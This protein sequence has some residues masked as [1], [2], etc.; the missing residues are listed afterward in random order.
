MEPT[1]A[2]S[3]QAAA[4]STSALSIGKGQPNKRGNGGKAARQALSGANGQSPSNSMN[5]TSKRKGEPNGRQTASASSPKLV[6]APNGAVKPNGAHVQPPSSRSTSPAPSTSSSSVPASEPIKASSST[7][8]TSDDTLART[9][10]SS[11]TLSEIEVQQATESKVAEDTTASRARAVSSASTSHSGARRASSAASASASA[12]SLD[13]TEYLYETGF[14]GAQ[15]SDVRVYVWNRSYSLH[16]LLL[17]RSPTLA[18]CM[19][20]YASPTDFGLSITDPA[21]TEEGLAIALSHLYSTRALRQI[22]VHNAQ[23][24]FAAAVFLQLDDLVAIAEP[25]CATAVTH[26]ADADSVAAWTAFVEARQ[27]VTPAPN[28]FGLSPVLASTP[29]DPE[30]LDDDPSTRLYGQSALLLRSVLLDHL[31]VTLPASLGAFGPTTTPD[32]RK[33]G[34]P[35]LS[36]IYSRLPF[37]YFKHIMESPRLAVSS[38]MERFNFARN[39]IGSRKRLQ[40]QDFDENVVLAFGGQTSHGNVN[41]VRKQRR[42]RTL[43]KVES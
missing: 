11:L 21:I 20:M 16:R 42:S 33:L 9:T 6:S 29:E 32:M 35:R 27:A 30:T 43:W 22:N 34:Q 7:E 10:Q 40:S 2:S 28:P 3:T 14:N 15:W 5:G 36:A 23:S 8:G 38:D 4:P 24:V 37:A 12:H 39:C 31:M 17:S 25:L 18:Q 13:I 19:R 1:D 26:A 41:V